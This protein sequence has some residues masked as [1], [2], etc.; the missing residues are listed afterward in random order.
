MR[1]TEKGT[2][3]RKEEN[4]W[5][6]QEGNVSIRKGKIDGVPVNR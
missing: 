4:S 1:E 6:W 2:H 3:K 5:W